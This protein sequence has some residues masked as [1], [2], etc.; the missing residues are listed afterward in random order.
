MT[1]AL[2]G[3]SGSTG[4][5]DEPLVRN[6]IASLNRG[7]IANA[8]TLRCPLAQVEESK[9]QLFA[10]QADGL[11]IAAGGSLDVAALERAK[12]PSSR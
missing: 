11:R 1:V 8:M 3:C 2:A 10:E 12:K 9:R 5:N 6:Y 7:D 4:A